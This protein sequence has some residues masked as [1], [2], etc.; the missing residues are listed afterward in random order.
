MINNAAVYNPYTVKSNIYLVVFSNIEFYVIFIL[1][2]N[3]KE[4]TA[5]LYQNLITFP[6]F[7]KEDRIS[8]MFLW[9]RV[10]AE[11]VCHIAKTTRKI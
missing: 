9:E 4:I 5:N 7:F 3:I 8:I 1:S 2:I 10:T 6:R 11:N